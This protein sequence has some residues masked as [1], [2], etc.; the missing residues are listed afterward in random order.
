MKTQA[1]SRLVRVG[2]VSA[3]TKSI[4]VLPPTEAGSLFLGEPTA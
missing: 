2:R 1:T 3:L 4:V